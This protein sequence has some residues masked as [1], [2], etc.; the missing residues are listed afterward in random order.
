MHGQC[1]EREQNQKCLLRIL[2][3][4][5]D[6]TDSTGSRASSTRAQIRVTGRDAGKAK[7]KGQQGS[8]FSVTAGAGSLCV[9]SGRG[10]LL[11]ALTGARLGTMHKGNGRT[12]PRKR[13]D[14]SQE[15]ECLC[16]CMR[17]GR[18]RRKCHKSHIPEELSPFPPSG[19]V[20]SFRTLRI[21]LY[22]Y[23]ALNHISWQ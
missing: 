5:T 1:S 20:C 8:C 2:V 21:T 11:T 17:P 18:E 15:E 9:L 4:Q 13:G 14:G 23:F 3:V 6:A 19:P 12:I 10:G 7:A 22:L 16:Q